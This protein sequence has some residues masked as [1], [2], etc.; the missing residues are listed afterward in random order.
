MCVRARVWGREVNP[1]I[2]RTMSFGVRG[3]N[4]GLGEGRRVAGGVES[5]RKESR[6][7]LSLS[8]PILPR[9]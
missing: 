5:V 3:L 8:R 1:E 9:Y 2:N 4:L 6:V 7:L